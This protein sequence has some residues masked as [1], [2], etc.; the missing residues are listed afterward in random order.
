MIAIPTREPNPDSSSSHDSGISD[1]RGTNLWLMAPRSTLTAKRFGLRFTDRSLT[2]C[3]D[4]ELDGIRTEF[5]DFISTQ[6]LSLE[7]VVGVP[8]NNGTTSNLHA[9]SLAAN[10]NNRDLVICSDL[11]HKS[12]AQACHITKQTAQPIYCSRNCNFR[13]PREDLIRFLKDHGDRVSCLVVTIGTTQLGTMN[14]FPFDPEIAALLKEKKIWL[15]VDAAMGIQAHLTA[16]NETTRLLLANADSVMIDPH[17]FVGVMDLSL[18][19]V[20][21]SHIKSTNLP[22]QHYFPGLQT[23]FGTTRGG[24]PIAVAWKTIQMWN[25]IEGVR[26]IAETRHRWAKSL[27]TSIQKA[28]YDLV[29]PLETTIIAVDMGMRNGEP[30][31]DTPE[32]TAE[33]IAQI[34]A[35]NYQNLLSEVHG[36]AV[37]KLHLETVDRSIHGLRIVITPKREITKT[38]IQKTARAFDR[39]SRTSMMQVLPVKKPERF[40]R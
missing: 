38:I 32:Q 39:M 25:G 40:G 5:C 36:L 6:I 27:S 26:K 30:I 8:F 24:F 2:D 3:S 28:G 35:V 21:E 13:V 33:C 20:K 10:H 14:D 12:I 23:Q 37:G 11:S 17:K 34:R 16:S 19:F 29:A 18:L 9:I 1:G 15:H 22:D 31:T 4:I 7:N